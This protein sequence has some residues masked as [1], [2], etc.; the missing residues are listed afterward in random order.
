ARMVRE[1]RAFGFKWIPPLPPEPT[2]GEALLS[3]KNQI[4][5][6]QFLVLEEFAFRV[7][8]EKSVNEIGRWF[9]KLL[10][11][12]ETYFREHLSR[13]L[14]VVSDTVLSTLLELSMEVVTRIRINPE[15]GTV[16]EGALWNEEHF[17]AET[18]LY[19]FVLAEEAR[20]KQA[21]RV[22]EVVEKIK[23]LAG[24]V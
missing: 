17:P 8:E 3:P 7:Q 1:L 15:T 10:F 2:D 19:G 20:G 12:H 16:A 21:L 24:V 11:P 13:N 9:A 22:K 5:E 18:V 6:G 14:V 4:S 23:G